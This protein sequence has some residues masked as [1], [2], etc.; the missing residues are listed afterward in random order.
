MQTVDYTL[1]KYLSTVAI[2]DF[3]P[4]TWLFWPIVM[5][6]CKAPVSMNI[7]QV[8][9]NNAPVCLSTVRSQ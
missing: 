6:V 1:F 3:E 5:K 9:L 2:I 7:T 8:G 4:E